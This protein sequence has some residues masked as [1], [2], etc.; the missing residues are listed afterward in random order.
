VLDQKETP[1]LGDNIT[2]AGFRDRFRNAPT[3]QP[4]AVVKADPSRDNEIRALS[5]ATISSESVAA[6]VNNALANCRGPLQGL[7]AQ[8]GPERQRLVE[9]T[10]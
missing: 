7:T 5:G 3:G 9:P 1:G 4:L 6:I 8:A 10:Q 2:T